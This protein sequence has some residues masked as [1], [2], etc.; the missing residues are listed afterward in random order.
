[1]AP[2]VAWEQKTIDIDGDTEN[3]LRL[4]RREED[5]LFRL[6]SAFAEKLHYNLDRI[7]PRS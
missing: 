2:E 4:C 6:C 7:D 5:S 1:M 3:H